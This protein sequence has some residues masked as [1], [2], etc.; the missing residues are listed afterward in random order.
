MKALGAFTFTFTFTYVIEMRQKIPRWWFLDA[1]SHFCTRGCARPSVGVSHGSRNSK[2][3]Y[4]L[5]TFQLKSIMNKKLCHLKF[6]SETCE[7]IARTHLMSE[8]ELC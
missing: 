5:T 4:F 6:D 1:I 7:Q 2:K 3:F 8:R